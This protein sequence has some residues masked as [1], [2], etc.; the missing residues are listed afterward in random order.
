MH[1]IDKKIIELSEFHALGQY[2]SGDIPYEKG[3]D[4]I[5]E[6]LRN[7]ENDEYSAWEPFEHDDNETIIGYIEVLKEQQME[8]LTNFKDLI[9]DN[10]I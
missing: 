3:Y 10:L 7:N 2:L 8:L 5:I 6:E 1:I 9:I 4:F